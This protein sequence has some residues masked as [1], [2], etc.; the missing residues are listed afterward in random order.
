MMVT[1]G[2]MLEQ[3]TEYGAIADGRMAGGTHVR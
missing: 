3:W 1:R 2:T